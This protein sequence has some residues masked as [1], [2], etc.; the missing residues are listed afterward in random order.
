MKNES[1]NFEAENSVDLL[2]NNKDIMIVSIDLFY[3]NE[4]N[5]CNRNRCN[6]SRESAEKSLNSFKNKPIIFRYNNI[7]PYAVTDVTEHSNNSNEEFNTRI[8]GHIPS[9]SRIKFIERENGKTYCNVEAVIQKRY[10][11]QLVDILKINKGIIKVSIEINAYGETNNDGIYYISKFDLQGVC[12]LGRKVEEGIEGS[13]L[14]V[15]KFSNMELEKYN[16]VYLEFAK[17]Q[18]NIYSKIKGNGVYMENNKEYGTGAEIKVDKS[19]ESMSYDNWGD[20]DKIDLRE[21]VLNAKNYKTLVHEVYMQVEDGWED[22][23]SEK[24]KY[25]VMQIK[26][27]VAVYN[28]YGLA[29]ALG[30]AK[31][32]NNKM[33]VDK[34]KKLYETINIDKED[35]MKQSEDLLNK[36]DKDNPE[37]EKIRQDAD[38]IE[39]N[40]KEKLNTVIDK[41][42][43]E[44]LADDID[45]DKDYWKDKF[46]KLETEYN[47]KI[48][49]LNICK[50]SLNV[51]QDELNSCKTD[52]QKYIRK[53]DIEQKKKKIC[54]MKLILLKELTLKRKLTIKSKNLQKNFQK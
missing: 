1:L 41:P 54:F 9:D 13:H 11:P 22:A 24:L 47:D 5:D 17:K 6:I 10:L 53:E 20:I 44:K 2:Y 49:E 16:Q 14:E 29:S 34:V 50:E 46:T 39:D 38:S 52:L 12:L 23:P 4:E 45:S 40:E 26:D 28:R 42:E 35:K 33:V 19:L 18:D 31:A 21:K 37:L 25:P 3:I 32:D 48:A 8:A 7:T 15:L 36:L 30:Y 27:N 43:N 51:C